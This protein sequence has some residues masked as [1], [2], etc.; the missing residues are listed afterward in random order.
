MDQICVDELKII[1]EDKNKKLYAK[2]KGDS[3]LDTTEYVKILFSENILE[4]IEFL[5][6]LNGKTIFK[7]RHANAV[8][9]NML[10]QT[11][12]FMYLLKFIKNGGYI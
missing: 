7:V 11:I 1:I 12:E 10:E 5:S 2:L 9:R 3:I 4:D 8:I 6:S